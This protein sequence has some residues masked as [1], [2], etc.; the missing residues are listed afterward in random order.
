MMQV[1][2]HD[3]A[4]LSAIPAPSLLAYLKAADW[5]SGG[6][7][8]DRAILYTKQ[9]QGRQWDILVPLKDTV[10]DFAQNMAES[11][12]ILSVV[13]QRSQLDVYRDLLA[14]G[15][16][17]IRLSALDRYNS[18]SFS[19][20][21]TGQLFGEA[22]ALLSAAARAA[23]RPR[24]AY[25]GAASKDVS[26]F[27]D[28]IVPAPTDFDGFDLTLYSPLVHFGQAELLSE[29]PQL[30]FSRRAVL[31]LANGLSAAEEAIAESHAIN[32]LEPFERAVPAGVSANLCAAI[33]GL[34]EQSHEFGSGCSVD[35]RWA[36]TRPQGRV[37]N[38][39]VPFSIH[40]VGTLYDA[41]Q[42]LL[43]R[44]SF[45]DE[46]VVG[47]PVVLARKRDQQ[48]GRALVLPDRADLPSRLEVRLN[49]SDYDK[50]IQAFRRQVKIELDGDIHPKGNGYELRNPRNVRLLEG[51][52]E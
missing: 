43:A 8:G 40:S 27:L 2:I 15:T 25:R 51:P 24:E 28:H 33:A 39:R 46:H 48:E 7:W 12:Q 44:A 26:H 16:D 50:V 34:T 22:H 11:I 35:V 41:R 32:S 23:E 36:A 9:H 20:H 52:G 10:A 18:R 45:S 29:T 14:A 21:D 37:A 17:V 42:H 1:D 6:D 3:R 19:L 31:A 30:P 5:E 4:A 13:E 47:D 49:K 38:A